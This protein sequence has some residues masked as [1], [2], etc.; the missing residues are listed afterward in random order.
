MSENGSGRRS[1][2]TQRY[3][4]EDSFVVV[5]RLLQQGGDA[6]PHVGG[7]ESYWLL[8]CSECEGETL[9]VYTDS[10]KVSCINESCEEISTKSVTL[11]A[12]VAELCDYERSENRQQIWSRIQ[13]ELEEN[14]RLR[15]EEAQR[16]TSEL[17]QRLEAVQ[18]ESMKRL[19]SLQEFQERESDA[20]QKIGN[21]EAK[22]KELLESMEVRTSRRLKIASA[23]V[24]VAALL[25]ALVWVSLVQSVVRVEVAV[26]V[27]VAVSAAVAA[28]LATAFHQGRGRDLEANPLAEP[29][30][31]RID[32]GTV[33]G[34]G[35]KFLLS[36]VAPVILLD[37]LVGVEEVAAELPAAESL[38]WETLV[39]GA[40][41]GIFVHY[42]WWASK[43]PLAPQR[44]R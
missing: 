35:K 26:A 38:W 43:T 24:V 42:F 28:M 17:E 13:H 19:R 12:A 3:A 1:G 21:L 2:A 5:A 36:F 37:L 27:N 25:G 20:Q 11:F 40:A 7:T 32:L 10:G 4:P 8:R 44:K 15:W 29:F 30:Y 33:V 39:T 41:L 9:R 22:I 31:R 34:W 23:V 14:E 16:Y 6:E 18:D